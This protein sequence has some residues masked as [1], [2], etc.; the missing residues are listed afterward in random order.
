MI[1]WD[2]ISS[3][4]LSPSTVIQ[5][6]RSAAALVAAARQGHRA[7]V[8]F[9]FYLDHMSSAKFHY[10]NDLRFDSMTGQVER[11]RVLGGEACLWTEYIDGRM[12]H[13][14][15]WPRTAAIAERLW[16]SATDSVHCMYERLATI[17]RRFFHPNDEQYHSDLSTMTNNVTALKLL[18]DLC[19]PL[20][21]QGRDQRRLYTQRTPLNRFVD[22]IRPESERTRQL[23]ETTN[24]ATLQATFDAWSNN[25]VHLRTNDTDIHQLSSH[26]AQLGRLG[27]NLLNIMDER[28][29]MPIVSARWLD[30]HR[31]R[32]H[33]IEYAVPE[34]RL[35]AVRVVM[36]LLEPLEPCSFDLLNLVL[37]LFCPL[38]V[39]VGH[40]KCIRRRFLVAFLNICHLTC[41]RC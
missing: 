9:G 18:A 27:I 40:V 36:H 20:G 16:S 31:S 38:L 3:P 29:S 14:R 37:I 24:V 30:H 22:I 39:I 26:L 34:I 33:S 32:L 23:I 41:T 35:A 13:S 28:Q 8:S 1:G 5:S 7:I 21:L 11:T 17:D 25:Q 2:E 15:V 6:W 10:E 4:Q 19:E 12:A